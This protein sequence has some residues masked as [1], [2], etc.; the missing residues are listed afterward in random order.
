MKELTLAKACDHLDAA[1]KSRLSA[2][3]CGDG[4]QCLHRQQINHNLV[5]PRTIKLVE[6]EQLLA[7]IRMIQWNT[8]CVKYPPVLERDL[9]ILLSSC[10]DKLEEA[11]C[12]YTNLDRE[13]GTDQ[14][15]GGATSNL[16]VKRYTTLVNEWNENVE[17]ALSALR[18]LEQN[19]KQRFARSSMSVTPPLY[20]PES[21]SSFTLIVHV[22]IQ[23]YSSLAYE[24]GFLIRLPRN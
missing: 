18:N 8:S 2:R 19:M 14:A 11:A 7:Y 5:Q 10:F 6:V 23:L 3:I 1:V 9:V 17:R 4:C 21:P 12:V 15:F 16:G 13:L 24:T 22:F 20:S